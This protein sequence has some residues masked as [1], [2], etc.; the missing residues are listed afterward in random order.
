MKTRRMTM[1]QALIAFLKQQHV[2]RDGREH[3]FFAGVLGIFGHGNVAGI[4]QA[5]KRISIS[6]TYCAQ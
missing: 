6:L 3:A 5:L 2:E 1:A 4:G